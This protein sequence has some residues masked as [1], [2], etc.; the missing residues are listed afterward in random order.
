MT[1]TVDL[2]AD[3]QGHLLARAAVSG[4]NVE[5]MIVILLRDT[6]ASLDSTE[7]SP[8][9]PQRLD[10]GVYPDDDG[11]TGEVT[12]QPVSFSPAGAVTA[13]LIPAGRLIP[14]TFP[15]AE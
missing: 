2:P 7:R 9:P 10:P 14:A 15:E 12:Y 4:R 6:V 3:L 11:V 8:M 13:H 5:E 1:V